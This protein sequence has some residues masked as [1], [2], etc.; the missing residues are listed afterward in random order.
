MS[1]ERRIGNINIEGAQIVLK[2]FAGK[3]KTY[4]PAGKRNFGVLLSDDMADDLLA[5][6]WNVKRF[7]P[8]PDDPEQYCQPWLSVNVKFEPYPP[9]VVLINSRGKKRLTEDTVEM[10]DW[11]RFKYCD[12]VIRPYQYPAMPGRPNGGVAAYLKAIYV[13]IWEEEFE[14]RYADLVDLDER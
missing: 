3:E 4:N 5:D 11:T 1:E 12:L 7:K 14:D 8:Q 10:L 6:G 2:N 9:T 13:T